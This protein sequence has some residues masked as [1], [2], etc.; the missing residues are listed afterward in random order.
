MLNIIFLLLT[1]EIFWQLSDKLYRVLVDGL[2]TLAALLFA[3]DVKL[4]GSAR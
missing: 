2:V 1:T 3:T 4:G